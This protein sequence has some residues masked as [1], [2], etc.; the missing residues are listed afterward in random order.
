[1]IKYLKNFIISQKYDSMIEKSA[2]IDKYSKFQGKNRVCN[3]ARIINSKF[4][5]ASY[6]GINSNIINTSIGKFSSIGPNV[7]TI[8]G[9]HPTHTYVS[10][11]PAFFSL[12]KQVGFTYIKEQKFSEFK[13]SDKN[14]MYSIKI[15]NDVW[16]GSNVKIIEGVTI[17]DGAIIAAGSL[18]AKN[19]EP[20][21]IVGGVPAKVIKLR[22]N[23]DQI[24]FLLD[25]K[26]WDKDE[27]WLKKNAA[28]FDNIEKFMKNN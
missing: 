4:G 3:G 28:D 13:Y 27:K 12:R 16:I 11:H 20:Y 15:G 14:D 26:W 17:G 8:I 24:K 5:Y 7:D 25:F 23:K 18:V 9:R 6:V 22:F 2:K 21:S 10:T 19:V 1:M